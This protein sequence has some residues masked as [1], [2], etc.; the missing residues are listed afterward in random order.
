VKVC[1]LVM[2]V[3]CFEG[4]DR[5]DQETGDKMFSRSLWPKANGSD[6]LSFSSDSFREL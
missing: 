4:G 5:D 1:S 2:E 6:K 3:F